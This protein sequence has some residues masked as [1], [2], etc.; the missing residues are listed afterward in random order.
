VRIPKQTA[1]FAQPSRHGSVGLEAHDGRPQ[2]GRAIDDEFDRMGDAAVFYY[3]TFR[4]RSINQSWNHQCLTTDLEQVR[5][6][7]RE[8]V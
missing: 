5:T 6:V 1:A 4:R 3:A 2:A 8:S 7:E